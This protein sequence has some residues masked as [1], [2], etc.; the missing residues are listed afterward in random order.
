MKVAVLVKGVFS[1]ATEEVNREGQQSKTAEAVELTL[2]ECGHETTMLSL[3]PPDFALLRDLDQ[4]VIFNLYAVSGD[5]QALVSSLLEIVGVPYTGCS[6]L[7]HF[8]ALNKQQAKSVWLDKGVR[9]PPAPKGETPSSSEFPLF[10]KPA[11]GGSGEGVYPSSIVNNQA[12]LD[13][14]LAWMDQSFSPLVVEQY[15]PGRELT[16]GLLGD[17]VRVLPPLEISFDRLPPGY[18]PINTFD[19]KH[20]YYDLVDVGKADLS[21]EVEAEVRR[22]A[23]EAFEALELRDCARADFR[24]D[25]DGLPWIVEINSLPGLQPKYSY[26]PQAADLAGMS[27]RDLI[28]EML[29][30]ALD[31][32]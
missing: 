17:P 31:R 14:H 5:E 9:T 27:F 10:V 12:E 6:P 4:D 21:P 3:A 26:L 23:L 25:D 19:A 8:L 2:Q 29:Q 13:K 22:V 7:G 16:V 20:K 30:L 28:L 32:G 15:I 18:P 11:R 24:L 1:Q